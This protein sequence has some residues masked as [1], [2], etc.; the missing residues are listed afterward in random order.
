MPAWYARFQGRGLARVLTGLGIPHVGEHTADLLAQEFGNIDD[1]VAASADRLAQVVGIGSV[2]AESVHKYFH[3]VSGRKVVDEL[4][5]LGVKLT[6]DARPTA[7]QLG[8]ADLTGKIFVVTGTLEFYSR[9]EIEDL[10][11]KLGGKA[12][13]SV[14]K[15]TDYLVAGD[16]AGSKLDKAKQLGVQVLSE[17]EFDK[18]IGR[19][20]KDRAKKDSL[21]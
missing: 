9:D 3:S 20:D 16:K 19:S 12:T 18:L 13:G 17:K 4:R 7:A 11:K 6:E 15:N 14:S 5:S 10:I 8:G 21:F 2:V 1:L